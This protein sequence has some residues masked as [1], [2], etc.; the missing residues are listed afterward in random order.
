MFLEVKLSLCLILLH[1]DIY[2]I[3]AIAPCLLIC[4]LDRGKLSVSYSGLFSPGEGG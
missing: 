2:D 4:A 3:G 1:E